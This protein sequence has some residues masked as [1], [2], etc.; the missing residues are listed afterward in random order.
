MFFTGI[1][2]PGS[3]LSK[4]S[5][6]LFSKSIFKPL[7]IINTLY[8]TPVFLFFSVETHIM[9]SFSPTV[10]CSNNPTIPFFYYI[11]HY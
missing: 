5:S 1:R 3:M 7:L 2:L 6:T 10:I 8:N 9:L 11:I 4:K